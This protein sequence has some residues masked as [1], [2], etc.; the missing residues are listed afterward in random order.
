[1]FENAV[2]IQGRDAGTL[3]VSASAVVTGTPLEP[4]VYALWSDVD[5]YI[6][7]DKNSEVADDVTTTIGFKITANSCVLPVRIAS[8]SYLGAIA[9]E[10]GN[11]YYQQAS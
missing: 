2:N 4:G 11:L 1:M 5:V 9:T 3:T 7:V 6:K 8:D 10:G